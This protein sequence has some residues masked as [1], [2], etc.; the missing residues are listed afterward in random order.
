[1]LAGRTKRFDWNY[2]SSNVVRAP[3]KIPGRHRSNKTSA[4]LRTWMVGRTGTNKLQI[5][6]LCLSK[7]NIHSFIHK[8]IIRLRVLMY[9]ITR[10]MDPL[11]SGDYPTTMRKIIGPRLP[12]FSK[13]ES[14]RLKGSFDF[15]GFNHYT[16]AY[17]S[18]SSDQL[19]DRSSGEYASDMSAKVSC[20]SSL[21]N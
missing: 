10:F 17:I 16:V 13:M 11:F 14:R 19:P 9:Y 20:K 6:R 3:H 8:K 4:G 1:M 2:V 18:D 7:A 21:I 5:E 15:V 12:S